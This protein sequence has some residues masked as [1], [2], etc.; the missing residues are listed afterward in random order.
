VLAL[1]DGKLC[2]RITRPVNDVREKCIY[3]CVHA[4]LADLGYYSEVVGVGKVVELLVKSNG[5]A[6]FIV[7]VSL[8]EV[9]LVECHCVKA[10]LLNI[11]FLFLC[12][13]FCC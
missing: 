11:R 9:I 4:P 1:R 13:F 2:A 12:L 7:S 3:V 10:C 8:I 5:A 6:Q